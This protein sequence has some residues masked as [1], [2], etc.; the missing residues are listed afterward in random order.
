MG[1]KSPKSKL[2]KKSQ[3]DAASRADEAKAKAKVKQDRPAVPG[4]K[5]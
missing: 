5:K 4:G 3:K 1:D 2:K